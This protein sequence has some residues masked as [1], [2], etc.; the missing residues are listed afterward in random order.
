MPDSSCRLQAARHG[1]V[2][3]RD[4]GR[5]EQTTHAARGIHV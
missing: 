2:H 5:A 1:R 4:P 3:D